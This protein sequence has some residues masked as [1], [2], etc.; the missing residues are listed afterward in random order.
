MGEESATVAE[1][2][3]PRGWWMR[4]PQEQKL[5]LT[6]PLRKAH[7][8]SEAVSGTGVTLSEPLKAAY[9]A[10]AP[11]ATGQPTPGAAIQY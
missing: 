5:V 6:A 10:G 8:A 1:V 11:A 4:G 7:K 2:I 3:M 9:A